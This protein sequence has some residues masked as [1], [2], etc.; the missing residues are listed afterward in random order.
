MVKMIEWICVLR[1]KP[2]TRASLLAIRRSEPE[3][4]CFEG[5]NR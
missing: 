2:K 5:E 3:M 1:C 4:R